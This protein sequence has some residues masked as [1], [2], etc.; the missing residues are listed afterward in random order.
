MALSGKRRERANFLGADEKDGLQT[1]STGQGSRLYVSLE[2]GDRMKNQPAQPSS[3]K[4][5]LV[6]NEAQPILGQRGREIQPYGT[7]VDY[8][9][10]LSEE[11]KTENVAALNQ[12]L[13]DT[14]A[15]RDMYKKHHWQVSGPTFHQL[16]LLYDK[17]Y[18]EQ[19][20]LMDLVAERIQTL[21]GI[22][23]AMPH[24]IAEVTQ[25][26]RP[27]RGREEVPTQLSRLIDAHAQVIKEARAAA[28]ASTKNGDDATTNLLVGDVLP[29]NEM[30]VWV[31]AQHLVDAPLVKAR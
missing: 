13:G 4:G 8:P 28:R 15:L 10:D 23:L 5:A 25:I 30:Q 20:R 26:E 22:A 11:A 24:D 9:I 21:G 27:P 16:H 29:A 12:L 7:L 1:G 19:V 6:P 14:M 17:H 31:L 18:D 2:Q 3:T